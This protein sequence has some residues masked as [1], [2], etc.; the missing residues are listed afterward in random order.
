VTDEHQFVVCCDLDGV[1]WRGDDAIPGAADGVATLRAAGAHVTFLTNNS[2][3][4][5]SDYVDK[6]A[7]MGIDARGVDVATSAQAA[8]ALLHE[9]LPRGSTVLACAGPGVVEAL[10]RN[11]FFVVDEGP[12]DAVVVGWHREFNFERLARA[13]DAVRA[14]A[15]YIATNL[16]PT[17]PAADGMLPGA[18]AIAAAVTT[19]AGVEPVAAGKPNA[20]TVALVR[21]RFGRRG[22]MVGDRPSTDGAFAAALGWPFALVLSGVAG[23]K[24]GEPVPDPA[25]PYVA[26]DFGALAPML[27]DAID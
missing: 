23:S 7:R 21:S 9:E 11:A 16:D 2:S 10:E 19:A 24:G 14:G 20:P 26:D 22:V 13:S 12:A 25:P 27:L 1:I 8:A 3:G 18:G 4:R 6:L 5:V 15:R 17:Y